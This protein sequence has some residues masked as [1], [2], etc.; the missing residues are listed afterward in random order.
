MGR[1]GSSAC[2]YLLTLKPPASVHTSRIVAASSCSTGARSTSGWESPSSNHSPWCHFPCTS[3]TAEP[4][5]NS[6][7]P[8][9]DGATTSAGPS[10]PGTPPGTPSERPERPPDVADEAAI[11]GLDPPGT[12]HRPDPGSMQMA[13]HRSGRFPHG[14][15]NREPPMDAVTDPGGDRLRLRSSS[16]EKRA[17]VSG[18]TLK[19]RN[20]I[21]MPSLSSRSQPKNCDVLPVQVPRAGSGRHLV[22]LT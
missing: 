5:S 22:G 14:L 7:W 18:S 1:S 3:R 4:R 20:T 11:A 15:S 19:S 16:W 10:P 6:L 21:Q 2:T 9:E 17:V 12:E 13:G 8:G